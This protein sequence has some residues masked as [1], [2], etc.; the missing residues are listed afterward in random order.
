MSSSE[1]G[2]I[3]IWLLVIGVAAALGEL[4]LVGVWGARLARRSRVLNERLLAQR[5][6][7]RADVE[8]LQASIDE[9]G[10]LWQP[11]GRLLR[12]LRH[13]IAIALLQSYARRRAAAR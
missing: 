12:W 2:W 1:L 5:A 7:L 4:A 9:T 10:V 11:Y 8:R 6:Q 3:G 13:P